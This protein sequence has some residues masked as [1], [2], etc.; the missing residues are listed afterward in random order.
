MQR[1]NNED[2][3]KDGALHTTDGN[4]VTLRNWELHTR[5]QLKQFT[6]DPEGEDQETSMQRAQKAKIFKMLQRAYDIPR[7]EII[8]GYALALAGL[9]FPLRSI[10]ESQRII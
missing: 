9:S 8:R 7:D 1:A 6:I 2:S 3:I 5:C 10:S 4:Q